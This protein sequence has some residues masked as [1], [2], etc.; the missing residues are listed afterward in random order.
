[1]PKTQVSR[2]SFLKFGVPG[3]VGLAGT[4]AVLARVARGGQPAAPEGGREPRYAPKTIEPAVGE[5]MDPGKFLAHFD[6][7]KVSKLSNGQTLR[8]YEVD[9]IDREVVVAK[10]VT[11]PAWTFNGYVPGPTLRA[12]Q[13]DRIRIHFRNLGAHPHTMH[14]HGIHPANMDGVFEWV[15]PKGGRFTYEFDAEPYGVHL[16]H[17]HVFPLKTHI[18]KGQYGTF[19][20]DPKEGRPPA[21][22]MVM[23]MNGFDTNL[24]GDNEFYTVNG[25]ANYYRDHPI[26]IRLGELVRVYLVNMTEFDP[27]NSMHIHANFFRLYRTGTRMDYYEYTDT[28]TLGQGERCILEFEYSHPGKFMFHAHQS[29]FAE[30]GWL[31]FF[32]VQ[33]DRPRA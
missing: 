30:L 9:A 14:F 5:G 15:P 31:G 33:P 1:M 18:M 32:D 8:E 19:I 28:V 2:R 16:Y 12:T 23:V 24:D 10:G 3:L 21:H 6:Y 20:I 26:R 25:V 29:E 22:E 7:G 4:G 13:G 17:C 27:I 11:F